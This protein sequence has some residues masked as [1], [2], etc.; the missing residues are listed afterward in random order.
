[1]AEAHRDEIAKLESLFAANPEGRIF[2]HLAEAY[3][4][5]GELDRALEVLETGIERHTD[6]SSAYVVLGRVH[7]D[8]ADA[9]AA[10]RSFRR[11]LELDPHNLVALRALG[12][13]ARDQGDSAEALEHYRQLLNLE[14]GNE[15]MGALVASLEAAPSGATAAVEPALTPEAEVAAEPP[16]F[17]AVD[18]E[19]S[20]SLGGP[21][22]E[23]EE[24][25]EEASFGGFSGLDLSFGSD[26]GPEQEPEPAAD[27]FAPLDAGAA[28]ASAE[29]EESEAAPLP[30]AQGAAE[31]PPAPAADDRWMPAPAPATEALVTETMGDLYAQQGLTE[32]AAEVYR[33]LLEIRGEDAGLR[34]K[35]ERLSTATAPAASAPDGE[36]PAV[37]AESPPPVEAEPPA[38]AEPA[39]YAAGTDAGMDT[40]EAEAPMWPEPAAEETV[41]SPPGGEP[42]LT[43]EQEQ[44]RIAGAV[45]PDTTVA[46][47]MESYFE[48]LFGEVPPEIGGVPLRDA[49]TPPAATDPFADSFFGAGDE[50]DWAGAPGAAGAA[51]ADQPEA[52]GEET[53]PAEAGSPEEASTPSAGDRDELPVAAP[54]ETPGSAAPEDGEPPDW[55]YDAEPERLEQIEAA[56]TGGQGAA[57]TDPSLYAWSE[58]EGEAPDDEPVS[59]YFGRLLSWRPARR[60][61][62]EASLGRAEE[63]SA[64][65]S[66]TA[67]APRSDDEIEAL[68]ST[69]VAGQPESRRPP[70]TAT[71]AP[72]AEA[73][74]EPDQEQEQD[75][76]MF[77]AWLQSLK[78]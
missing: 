62:G 17:E 68:F 21:P 12:D 77:R 29:T 38:E 2:T 51:E 1:M 58:E 64:A 42:L 66:P 49:S 27:A 9:E 33:K 31:E 72:A 67:P 5:A 26:Q 47:S 15:E 65:K 54:A 39:W 41:E 19:V 74:A 48:E 56:W 6:Y 24:A 61:A 78:H 23:T 43:E 73:D 69:P 13:L 70:I 59:A 55:G 7:A 75:L 60:A 50:Y 28:F 22:S 30:P 3:R 40:L 37:N 35:L 34:A 45:Q 53:A 32:R 71:P 25:P 46:A 10:R 14:P 18:L 11:V 57:A 20:G 8:R 44:E 52:A 4:K 36:E 76:E 63:S 16:A